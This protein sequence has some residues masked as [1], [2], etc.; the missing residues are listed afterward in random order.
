MKAFRKDIAKIDSLYQSRQPFYGELHDHSA[1]GDG[2]NTLAEWK[3]GL[4]ALHMD[5]A[6]IVD[7]HQVEHMYHP[8]FTDGIFLGG[9]EPGTTIT[10]MT[11]TRPR[12]HYNM[13][14]VDP[15]PLEQLVTEF[16][17][18]EFTGG[19]EGRFGYP[20]FTRQRFTQ[21]VHRVRE[22]GGF[23]VHPHP[24]QLMES[25]NALDYWFADRT[26]LEVLYT[27][28]QDRD[29]SNTADNYK[30]WTKLLELGKRVWATA[31]NDEHHMPSDKALT[32]VYAEKRSSAAY[33]EHLRNGDFVAGPVGIQMCI[34]DTTMG[35][36]CNFDGQ[37]L[38]LRIGDFHSSVLDATHTY[39]VIL[40]AGKYRVARCDF[41]CEE[42]RYFAWNVKSNVP[43]Y[44][45]EVWDMTLKSRI[46]IGNPI[47]NIK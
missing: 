35:G 25:E 17:E 22:L 3:D 31:G 41:S 21:L 10:D 6:T 39:R 46:A 34:G 43:F 11:A 7:H 20:K 16:E 32:T 15:K 45:A 5:F 14:F 28:H 8:D 26:G 29:G 47:W 40:Y 27:Y 36:K 23:F 19:P 37:R 12:L 13:I 9:T 24:K 44:R 33:L 18:Y 30:L 38:V 2:K 4:E 42:D 1:C